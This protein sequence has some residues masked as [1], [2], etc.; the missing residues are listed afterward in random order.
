MLKKMKIL[1][2]RATGEGK[3][4]ITVLMLNYYQKE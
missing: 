4:K 1:P 2:K 3:I